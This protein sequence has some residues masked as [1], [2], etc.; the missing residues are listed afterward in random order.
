MHVTEKQI[1]TLAYQ[2]A[3]FGAGAV[4]VEAPDVVM[5]TEIITD[6]VQKLIS[7][8]IENDGELEHQ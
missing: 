3:G 8:F 1:E 5:P 6:G 7:E 2:A 4:M